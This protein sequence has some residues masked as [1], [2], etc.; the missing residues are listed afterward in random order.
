MADSRAEAQRG[1]RAAK[2]KKRPTTKGSTY[3]RYPQWK[4]DLFRLGI[5]ELQQSYAR[6]VSGRARRTPG[7]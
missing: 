6:Q 7:A 5:A 1:Q 4:V 2:A 3:P